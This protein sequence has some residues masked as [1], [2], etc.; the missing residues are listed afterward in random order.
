MARKKPDDVLPILGW[1][2]RDWRASTARAA[3]SPLARGVYRELLDAH[4]AEKD[5]ALPDD[6]RVLAALAGVTLEVWQSV[7]A[8][9]LPWLPLTAKGRRQNRRAFE[10]WREAKAFRDGKREGGK[11][12]ADKR[13]HRDRSPMPEPLGP[14]A[15]PHPSS[16]IPHPHP[17]P[18]SGIQS[19]I[20]SVGSPEGAGPGGDGTEAAPPATALLLAA[21]PNAR[22]Q[23]PG[24]AGQSR[25]LESG[26]SYLTRLYPDG[27]AHEI[28]QRWIDRTRD[29][30]PSPGVLLRF[31]DPLAFADLEA[32]IAKRLP[33]LT[34]RDAYVRTA[35]AGAWASV[36]GRLR[37][38]HARRAREPRPVPEAAPAAPEAPERGYRVN[39]AVQSCAPRRPTWRTVRKPGRIPF[40]PEE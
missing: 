37:E 1:R 21:E 4:W 12:G 19:G 15:H 18:S 25:T 14:D 10:T 27:V 17:H 32:E 6:D 36:L 7:K 28:G 20:P 23:K 13:W 26:R 29:T 5:C 11:K 34:N 39:P 3:M 16:P 38:T 9:V 30:N 31:V 2:W 22:R 24:A 40:D 35:L 8:E 33:T